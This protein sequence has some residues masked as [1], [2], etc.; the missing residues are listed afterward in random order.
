MNREVNEIIFDKAPYGIFVVDSMGKYIEV[1][2]KAIQITGFARDEILRMTIADFVYQED[3][4]RGMALFSSV[5][6]TGSGYAELP[7]RHKRHGRR[8][9]SI[10][11]EKLS[12][13]KVIAF[14]YDITQRVQAEETNKAAEKAIQ[15]ANEEYSALNEELR[16][17]NDELIKTNEEL[18]YEKNDKQRVLDSITDMVIYHDVNMNV[19]WTNAPASDS[20]DQARHAILNKPCHESFGDEPGMICDNCPVLITLQERRPTKTVKKRSDG[21]IWDIKSYPVF[22][23][24]GQLIGAVETMTDITDREKTLSALHETEEKLRS[25]IHHAPTGI[26]ISDNNGKYLD[27]NPAATFMTGYSREE[28]LNMT[29]LDLYE[30]EVKEQIN[31]LKQE[32]INEGKTTLELPYLKKDGTKGYWMVQ[33]VVIGE[34]TYLGFATDISRLKAIQNQ[35]EDKVDE[36]AKFNKIMIGRENRMLQLKQ[37]VNVLLERLGEPIRYSAPANVKRSPDSGF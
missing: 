19:V 16:Q 21:K 4:E 33:A 14:C 23:E 11:A 31:A 1:N 15:E 2:E 3:I 30:P 20:I 5:M 7:F 37:E 25:Y 35:L 29:L 27:V 8:W 32:F 34:E 22:G 6:K 12:E 26:F 24:N 36:L 9:W 18:E 28:L 10:A 13:E 17:T